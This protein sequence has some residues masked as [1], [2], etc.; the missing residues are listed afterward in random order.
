MEDCIG[1]VEA[2]FRGWAESA[3]ANRPRVR[4]TIKG[5]TLHTL[6]AASE[7]SGRMAAKVY[8]TT[9][10]GARFVVLLFDGRTSDLLAIIEADRLGR[11]RTVRALQ[12]LQV[13]RMR[14]MGAPQRPR[15]AH[16]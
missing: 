7:S 16:Q 1:A 4:A 5:A 14:P 12:V 3:L 13:S 9:R 8:A 2:A 6:S 10:G 15:V 11:T